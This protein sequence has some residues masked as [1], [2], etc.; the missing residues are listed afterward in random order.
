MDDKNEII[1]AMK[2]INSKGNKASKD[3]RNMS[4]TV[5]RMKLLKD[6]LRK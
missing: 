5:G 3:I 2:E 4:A 1:E 6:S